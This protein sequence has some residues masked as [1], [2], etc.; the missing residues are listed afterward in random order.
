MSTLMPISTSMISWICKHSI[1]EQNVTKIHNFGWVGSVTSITKKWEKC[2]RVEHVQ[3]VCYKQIS[4][5]CWP[6][7]NILNRKKTNTRNK[8]KM[9]FSWSN[10]RQH[11]SW[12]LLNVI[13]LKMSSFIR[14]RTPRVYSLGDCFAIE[15]L[16]SVS[17]GDLMWRANV[18]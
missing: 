7:V 14:I 6:M 2:N 9:Y 13:W 17:W 15:R 3:C 4:Q 10:L 16:A 12:F 5:N 11:F 8:A 1:F 18:K